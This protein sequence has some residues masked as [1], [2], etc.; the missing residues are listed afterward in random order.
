MP[1]A[2]TVLGV[3]VGLLVANH[4]RRHPIAR[5]QRFAACH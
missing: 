4:V 1:A 5:T 3:D 2:L